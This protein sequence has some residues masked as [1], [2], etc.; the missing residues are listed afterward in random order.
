MHKTASFLCAVAVQSVL[1]P[2]SVKAEESESAAIVV[3][4]TGSSQDRDET[5]Q[6][7]S[8]IDAET[9]LQSQAQSVAELLLRIPSVRTNSNGNLGSVT[10]VS[11]RGSETGQVLVLLD[12]VAI[13][14]PSGTS[15]AVDFG[16]FLTGNI[17]RIEVMRGS[18]SVAFG[19]EAIG[20][21]IAI[22]TREEDPREGVS[23]DLLAEG[24]FANTARGSVDVGWNTN[25]IRIDAGLAAL[26]TDGISAV[27]PD[28]GAIERDGLRNLA[29]HARMEVQLAQGITLD[30]RG[31]GVDAWLDYDSF[32]GAPSDST[33]SSHF[34]QFTGYAG[35]DV[36]SIGGAMSSN[37]SLTYLANGRDYRFAP[38][39]PVDFGYRGTG[40]TF[41]YRGRV[42]LAE[43]ADLLLGYSH[44][45][46]SYRF[47]GFGSEEAHDASTDSGF[48]MMVLNP[49]QD[50]TLTG[51]LRH[52]RHSEFG[53]VT[54]FGLNA[55]LGLGDGLTRFRAAYGEGFRTPSLYQL[56]DSF[57]GNPALSPERSQSFDIGVDR[58]VLEGRGEV[59]LTVFARTTTNQID[60]DFTTFSY[61]NLGRTRS[62]GFEVEARL[63]PASGLDLSLAYS[64]VDA[65]DRSP[66]SASFDQKLPR[67]P[68]HGLSLGL[69][70]LWQSGFS[71]GLTLTWVSDALD[72]AAAEGL[73]GYALFGVRAALPLTGTIEAFA[74]VDNLFDADHVTAYGYNSAPRAVYGGFRLHI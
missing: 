46:P 20:G 49:G 6:T 35:L 19:S 53:G 56:Y 32:F 14:D 3:T 2:G 71:T 50:M 54:T 10:G 8:V 31:Y 37:L 58:S 41:A 61:A 5:G 39:T 34:G 42:K 55:N 24:G 12:G 43:S 40:W 59:S 73:D 23:L 1:L 69:D 66:G 44:D 22:S 33:D 9:I 15:G 4:A 17:K 38:D 7:I 18:N 64:L 47:F 60:F 70:K 52:D 57:S 51:G 27:D 16:N 26:R 48:A 67:R 74:R 28:L 25:S 11:L 29:A 72:P 30:L 45:A 13:N 21:V 65:R 62:R 63:Q 36:S 68:T